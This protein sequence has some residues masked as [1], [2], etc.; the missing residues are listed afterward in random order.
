MPNLYDRINW[1]PK[2]LFDEIK[3]YIISS[4]K[5]GRQ[6]WSLLKKG[7]GAKWQPHEYQKIMELTGCSF[8]EI[9]NPDINLLKVFIRNKEIEERMAKRE[10]AK[11]YGL[12]LPKIKDS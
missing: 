10:L 12:Y 1:L 6:R 8:E 2:F 9:L 7:K 5:S 11:K 4:S 3:N